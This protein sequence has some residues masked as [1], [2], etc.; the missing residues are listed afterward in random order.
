MPLRTNVAI[1]TQ[2]YQDIQRF[3]SPVS[4]PSSFAVINAAS[5]TINGGELEADACRPIES[6]EI[7][8]YYAHIDASYDDFVTGAGDF[9]ENEFAQVPEDQY[10]AWVRYALPLAES[11]GGITL[12]AN[13]AYQSRVFYSDTAPGRRAGPGG[14]PGPGR[15]WASEPAR[16]LDGLFADATRPRGL[17]QERDGDRVQHVRHPCCIRRSATTSPRSAS[18]ACSGSR[19]RTGSDGRYVEVSSDNYRPGA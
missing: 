16:R 2:D 9:T 14:E 11:I 5:A 8:A 13:Y 6:L 19:P 7:S 1:Y 10:S 3:T 18:R 4:N 17:R 12:Q 15:L